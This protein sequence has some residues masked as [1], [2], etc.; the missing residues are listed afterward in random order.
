[1][2]FVS[3]AWAEAPVVAVAPIRQSG[4]ELSADDV[5]TVTE[6]ALLATGA[7]TSDS[8]LT[9]AALTLAGKDCGE[10]DGCLKTFALQV[11]ALYALHLSL[12]ADAASLTLEGRVV[13]DD[14]PRVAGP[15][16]VKISREGKDAKTAVRAALN[17][18]LEQLAVGQLP[19]SRLALSAEPKPVAPSPSPQTA[20]APAL[21]QRPDVTAPAAPK[22]SAGVPLLIAG[23]IAAAAGAGLVVGAHVAWLSHVEFSSGVPYPKDNDVML[24]G[25]AAASAPNWRTVGWVATGVGGAVALLGA[26]VL[27]SS[28]PRAQAPVALSFSPTANGAFLGLSGSLP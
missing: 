21:T 12:L 4:F 18:L 25:P 7:V 6:R 14:G 19:P 17:A 13:R 11:K 28:A 9:Q 16:S 26:V 1:M 15:K 10:D 2:V 8:A 24:H 23:G 3:A 20:A 5:R 22:S 27:A